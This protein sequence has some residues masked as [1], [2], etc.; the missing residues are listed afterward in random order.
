MRYEQEFQASLNSTFVITIPFLYLNSPA[1][2]ATLRVFIDPDGNNWGSDTFYDITNQGLYD[3]TGT[4]L[5]AGYSLGIQQLGGVS[6]QLTFYFGN[7]YGAAFTG[8]GVQSFADPVNNWLWVS[9]P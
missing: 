1:D 2:L 3:S 9:I 4:T 6:W 7:A 5:L 8:S